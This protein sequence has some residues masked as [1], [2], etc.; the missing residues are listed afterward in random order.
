MDTNPLRARLERGDAALNGWLTIPSGLAAE[1]MAHAGFHSLTLD[2]QHAPIGFDAALPMLQA[3]TGTPATPLARAS[4]NEPAAIMRLL[5]AGAWG[6]ICPM[7]DSRDD[8]ERFV[9]ACRYPPRGARSWGPTRARFALGGYD[10]DEADRGVLAFAMVE[11]VAALDALDA[12]AATPGLDGIYVGPADL[13]RSL[14][15]GVTVDFAWPPL[16]AAL[17]RVAAAC[18]ANGVVAGVHATRP[19][20]AARLLTAGYRFVTVAADLDLLTRGAAATLAT[21]GEYGEGD[22]R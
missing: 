21:L 2:L 17:S 15:G 7:V 8:C 22:E 16:A 10:P 3:I 5:D 6:V 4:W 13:T 1:A 9:A 20:D 18:R 14:G 12:I 11:T 19:E